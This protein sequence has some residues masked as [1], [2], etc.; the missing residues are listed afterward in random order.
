M[1]EHDLADDYVTE[2]WDESSYL[3]EWLSS[4]SHLGVKAL[5]VLGP[6]PFGAPGDRE[7]FTVYPRQHTD[8]AVMLCRSDAYGAAWRASKSPLVGWSNLATLEPSPAGWPDRF[9][10]AGLASFVRV[11]MPL[12][13]DRAFECFVFCDEEI[14]DRSKAAELSYAMMSTWPVLK[15]AVTSAKLEISERERESL[16]AAADGLT[17]KQTADRMN[18]TERTVTHHWGNV[19]RKTRTPNRVA[20][21]LRVTLFGLI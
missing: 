1:L 12:P 16:V 20:A 9:K 4:I 17:A 18:C 11:E 14:T 19:M 6:N 13:M 21:V 15:E 8:A 2:D 7:V 3:P 5:V 10:S